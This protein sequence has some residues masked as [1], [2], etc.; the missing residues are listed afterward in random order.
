MNKVI[1]TVSMLLMACGGADPNS[2]YGENWRKNQA[3][4]AEAWKKEQHEREY[5]EIQRVRALMEGADF[6]QACFHKSPEEV[7]CTTIQMPR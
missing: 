5:K 6:L 7:V 4:L 1:M 2:M 3:L